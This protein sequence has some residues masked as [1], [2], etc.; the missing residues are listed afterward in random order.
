MHSL[1]NG[2]PFRADDTAGIIPVK[3]IDL[4]HLRDSRQ[5]IGKCLT[6]R[7]AGNNV[8]FI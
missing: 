5:K 7:K 2:R 6:P 4:V 3:A 1:V 8:S